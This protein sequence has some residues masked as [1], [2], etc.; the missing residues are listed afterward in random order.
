M[1]KRRSFSRRSLF[2]ISCVSAAEISLGPSNRGKP[3][4]FLPPV[5]CPSAGGQSHAYKG[6]AKGKKTEEKWRKRRVERSRVTAV[7]P[8]LLPRRRDLQ[9]RGSLPFLHPSTKKDRKR[10][11]SADSQLPIFDNETNGRPIEG[12]STDSL[13]REKKRSADRI[14]R[15]SRGEKRGCLF[16]V[17]VSSK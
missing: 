17:A 7:W 1:E 10:E 16:E 2:R 11:R 9:S 15:L 14:D 12:C 13:P 6:T 4:E 5:F 8:C 3:V